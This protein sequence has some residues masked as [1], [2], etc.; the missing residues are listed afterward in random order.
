[1]INYLFVYMQY[2]NED[3]KKKYVT[4]QALLHYNI[5]VLLIIIVDNSSIKFNTVK[6][7]N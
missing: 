3:I 1:M 5:N 7:Y 4:V 6:T 2:A